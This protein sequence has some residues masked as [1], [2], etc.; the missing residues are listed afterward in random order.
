MN[1][2]KTT[3]YG[4]KVRLEPLCEAHLPG[5]A[6]AIRDGELWKLPVTSVPHPDHLLQFLAD[7]DKQFHV[8]KE[9]AFATIDQASGAV[10]GS[11]RFRNIEAAHQR[12]EIGFTFIA[13]SWQR[14][15]INTEAKYLMLRHAFEHWLCNRVEL[16]TDCL[17][18]KS[19]AAIARLGAREEGV[20]RSH[21]VMRDGRIRDSVI[22]SLIA[23]EWP[24][25]KAQLA[26][27]LNAGEHQTNMD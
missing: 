25:A 4:S 9:L 26:D 24:L 17:N 27:R 5:L 21:M 13:Q 7:A 22:F 23:A 10:V 1:L 18:L 20:L 6:N 19:R 2:E 8:G 14:S 15:H 3:L 12:V 11:T 16:L